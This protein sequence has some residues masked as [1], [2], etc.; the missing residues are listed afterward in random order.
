[1]WRRRASRPAAKRRAESR[2]KRASTPAERRVENGRRVAGHASRQGGVRRR[3]GRPVLLHVSV[4]GFLRW[5]RV[6]RAR[7]RRVSLPPMATHSATAL[8]H[9]LDLLLV[10]LLCGGLLSVALLAGT[11]LT[12]LL[13]LSGAL[14]VL[15]V[16]DGEKRD[17]R[18]RV[19]WSRVGKRKY[20]W[21]LVGP[22][23]GVVCVMS[24]IQVIMYLSHSTQA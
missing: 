4:R 8:Q 11:A 10:A 2:R 15:C 24:S 19:V 23:F 21:V 16:C 7:R 1:M 5:P 3:P 9:H 14:L 6:R 17:K 22:G 13:L 12:M 20:S 18:E